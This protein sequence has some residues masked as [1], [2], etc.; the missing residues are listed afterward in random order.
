VSGLPV[1]S[2]AQVV[3]ALE[4]AGFIQVR[5][6]G[7][8]AVMRNPDTGRGVTVPLHTTVK[9]GTLAAILRQAG[10]NQDEFSAFL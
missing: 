8:H 5:T 3:K 9:R 6:K 7:S 10:V 4:K 1:L 2:G